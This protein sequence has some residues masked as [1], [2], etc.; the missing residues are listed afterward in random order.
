[1]H[2]G[3]QERLK[4][5]DDNPNNHKLEKVI[6]PRLIQQE[7]DKMCVVAKDLSKK[8]GSTFAVKDLSLTM[9]SGEI[10]C[11]LGHNG[12]GKT[13]TFNMLSGSLTKS[14]G[15]ITMLG[16]DMPNDIL[17]LR[18]KMGICPQYSVLWDDLSIMDHMRLFA[19]LRGF[20]WDNDK[21]VQESAHKIIFDLGLHKRENFKVS[22][23]SG[24][25]KRKLALGISFIGNPKIVFLDEPSSGMDPLARRSTWDLLK[26]RK[27]DCII[28]LTTHYMDEADA[29]SDRIAIVSKGKLECCGSPMFLK[30]L[31]GCGY[32]L[33]FVRSSSNNSNS[34]ESFVRSKLANGPGGS[35]VFVPISS[36]RMLSDS[37]KEVVVEVSVDDGDDRLRENFTALLVEFDDKSVLAS[38][39]VQ[40]YGI[41]VTNIEGVFLKVAGLTEGP[42]V[43]HNDQLDHVK[44][45][46]S[47]FSGFNALIKR[48]FWLLYREPIYL[49][50]ILIFVFLVGGVIPLISSALGG[51]SQSANEPIL[52][53]ARILNSNGLNPVLV[54]NS[55]SGPWLSYCNHPELFEESST[56]CT[57]VI[58]PIPTSTSRLAF[59]DVLRHR[60]KTYHAVDTNTDSFFSYS[61]SMEDLSNDNIFPRTS[62]AGPLKPLTTI[63]YNSK[64]VQGPAIA[65]LGHFNARAG[66]KVQLSITNHALPANVSHRGAGSPD[67]IALYIIGFA[68]SFLVGAC[69]FVVSLERVKKIKEQLII[70]GVSVKSYWITNF[71]FDAAIISVVFCVTAGTVLG[72]LDFQNIMESNQAITGVTILLVLTGFGIVSFSL[73]FGTLMFKSENTAIRVMMFVSFVFNPAL[74]VLSISNPGKD[75]GISGAF[76]MVLGNIGRLVPMYNFGY[77][78]AKIMISKTTEP[79]YDVFAFSNNT[80]IDWRIR[81]CGV[82]AEI[83]W[84]VVNI[85]TFLAIGYAIDQLS[86]HP[87]VQAYFA[88]KQNRVVTPPSV[89]Y[90]DEGVLAEERKVAALSDPKKSQIVCG[91]NLTK[92]FRGK[93]STRVVA[94]D[95]VSFC[96]D[97]PEIFGLLGTNGAGKTTTFKML[98]GLHYPSSGSVFLRGSDITKDGLKDVRH[99]IGYCGQEDALWGNMTV[100]EHLE[101]Y[102]AV[103]GYHG[104]TLKRAVA[105]MIEDM[106]LSTYATK[107]AKNLSGGYKRKLSAAMALIG[108]PQVVFLDE[109]SCGVDPFA[110]RKMWDIIQRLAES[111]QKNAV[112]IISTHSMEEAEAL[113]DR[114]AIQ[115]DGSFRSIGTCQEIKSRHGSDGF[116]VDFRCA[117]GGNASSVDQ[118]MSEWDLDMTAIDKIKFKPGDCVRFCKS[119]NQID[120]LK[121]SAFGFDFSSESLEITPT[122]LADWMYNDRIFGEAVSFLIGRFSN[123]KLELLDRNG[124]NM[125]VRIVGIVQIGHLFKELS[126]KKD[127]LY[128]EDFQV[129]QTTLEQ[130]FNRFATTSASKQDN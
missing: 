49:A 63:W 115:V 69:V 29:L 95:N 90:R 76:D 57:S 61:Q 123:H 23:L 65:L 99:T 129:S 40:S 45:N 88:V 15:T 17:Q 75:E 118:I 108:Q 7:R 28:C 126:I 112:I 4:T 58:E 110:R 20:D 84:L 94:V 114:V 60:A 5:E 59:Q 86:W 21:S 64:A 85:F 93:K 104:K 19:G 42:A 77:G 109:P 89:V 32:V 87:A 97:K 44:L 101:F 8:F 125:R 54:D 79:K 117:I 102:G 107:K 14:G 2:V 106:D 78:I 51:S 50:L 127:E 91:M 3:E 130:I 68:I 46:P 43:K 92:L 82:G 83:V 96:A 52:L 33:S 124:L 11:L 9:Y 105:Q 98:C 72:A 66:T 121:H 1:V 27:K 55:V 47:R 12:A 67:E 34:I 111:R 6:D 122:E 81:N 100:R 119:A 120:R 35:S 31:Y 53:D 25:M 16:H 39:G 103:R 22:A 18:Q 62:P 71:L 74:C 116:E 41:G 13:T 128:I 38:I 37:G 80:C 24:G 56:R 113:C 36:V 48:R 70:T 26:E 73:F 30:K 10:F